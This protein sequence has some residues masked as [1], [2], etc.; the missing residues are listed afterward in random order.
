MCTA[1]ARRAL[2]KGSRTVRDTITKAAKVSSFQSV[3]MWR[4]VVIADLI[5]GMR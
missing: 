4:V 5:G 3:Y 1:Q 2:K